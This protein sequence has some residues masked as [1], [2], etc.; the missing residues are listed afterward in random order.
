MIYDTPPS[1]LDELREK[2]NPNNLRDNFY[3]CHAF[4]HGLKNTF[5]LKIPYNLTFGLDEEIGTI[6]I[7]GNEEDMKHTRLKQPSQKNALTFTIRGNWIFWSDEPLEMSTSPAHYHNP[8]FNG[9][10][11]GGQFD[12]GRWFRPV[13]GAIQLHENINTVSFKRND[14]IAYVKFHTNEPIQFKRFY[15]TK[16]L[17]ELSWACIKYKRYEKSKSLPYLYNK[18][19]TR[20]LDKIITKEIKRNVVD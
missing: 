13:E 12:I 1:L 9:F 4:L 18:L 2:R 16:E 10:Y 8:I 6:F 17:E 14:P 15:I 5:I 7:D 3:S 11:V 19:T 20:G